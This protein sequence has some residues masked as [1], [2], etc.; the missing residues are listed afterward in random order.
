[1]KE[2]NRDIDVTIREDTL[3]CTI[4]L[5]NDDGDLSKAKVVCYG[6]L[7]LAEEQASIYFMNEAIRRRQ[8]ALLKPITPFKPG[9]A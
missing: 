7:K 8:N 4:P 5:K 3:V 1:M 6:A 2:G 9:V